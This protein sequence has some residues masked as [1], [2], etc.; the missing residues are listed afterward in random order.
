MISLFKDE[1]LSITFDTNLIETDV[2]DF[3]FNL[4]TEKYFFSKKPNNTLIYIHS[5][6]NHPRSII[7]QLPSMTNKR[8]SSI[9]CKGTKFNKAKIMYE[10]AL[11]NSGSQATIKFEKPSQNKRRNRNKKVIWFNPPFSLSIKTDIGKEF[12]KLIRKHFPRNH[13]FRKIFNL[14]TIRISFSLMKTMKNLIKQHD[15]RVLKNEEHSEK[16]SCN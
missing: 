1:G 14:N 10:T 15:A 4:N 7:K 3:S 9:S 12:F 2:L 8:I 6:S 11:K 16:I 5:K 13:S